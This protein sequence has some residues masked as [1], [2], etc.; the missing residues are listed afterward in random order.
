MPSPL[1]TATTINDIRD[2][3]P[4][5]NSKKTL[6]PQRKHR[7]L[8]RDGT[9]EVWPEVVEEVFVKGLREYW[10]SPWATYSRGRSR[11]RNQFL[12]DYLKK[13]GIERSKKQVASHIQVLRNMWKGE[14]EYHLV[15]GG[16]ELFLET[17]LLAPV[18]LEDPPDGD[19]LMSAH[20]DEPTDGSPFGQCLSMSDSSSSSPLSKCDASF[21]QQPSH[22]YQIPRAAEALT[23]LESLNLVFPSSPSTP[24][25]SSSH[26]IAL[27]PTHTPHTAP[28]ATPSF[29]HRSVPRFTPAYNPPA[30]DSSKRMEPRRNVGGHTYQNGALPT[31]LGQPPQNR[32]TG[33]S[34]WADGMST[35]SVPLDGGRVMARLKLRLPSID[36]SRSPPT[37]HG[38]HGTISLV[39]PWT[40]SAQCITSVHIGAVC[41]SRESASFQ[42]CMR[43]GRD[44]V[45]VF[46]PESPLSRSRWLD[47]SWQTSLTQQLVVDG[48][49]LAVVV[50]ELHR[51]DGVAP[52]AE[53]VSVQRH[54]SEKGPQPGAPHPSQSHSYTYPPPNHPPPAQSP[55]R[56]RP[57]EQ[58]SL[59]CALTP[60]TKNSGNSSMYGSR[61]TQLLF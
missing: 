12:V 59:S 55:V 32:V 26:H 2:M 43:N 53:L 34:V 3:S 51:L 29:N 14:P 22:E 45:T 41:A 19:S 61:S 39:S 44:P 47:A 5:A 24:G 9:S 54:D 50:Y 49:V 20:S 33:L 18:K 52:S 16:E 15:A 23:Q 46:L 17:G 58:T 42:P 6:T 31:A 38:F 56:S 27:P 57:F 60:I 37:L 10:E 11:W 36:D 13:A 25:S 48:S 4:N 30:S 1:T 28:Y 35:L 7:K 8:M 40:S 21:L